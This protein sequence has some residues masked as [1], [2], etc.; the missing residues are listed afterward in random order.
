MMVDRV[1]VGRQQR[2]Q[3]AAISLYISLT[4]G[5]LALTKLPGLVEELSGRGAVEGGE[6]V[7]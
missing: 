1:G 4:T 5:S 6:E 3:N 7:R 2:H